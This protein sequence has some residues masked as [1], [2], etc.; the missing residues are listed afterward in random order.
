M[1]ESASGNTTPKSLGRRSYKEAVEASL[2]QQPP[3]DE[4]RPATAAVI[5]TG[6]TAGTLPASASGPTAA[7]AA[8]VAPGFSSSGDTGMIVGGGG[9]SEVEE[10]GGGGVDAPA[11]PLGGG[12]RSV[13]GFGEPQQSAGG[14]GGAGVAAESPRKRSFFGSLKKALGSSSGNRA[15]E[16]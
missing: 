13:G 8:Q 15:G 9:P 16:A 6:S 4:T 2:A 14:A 11:G 3:T 7:A 5:P 12:A 10:Y 1:G